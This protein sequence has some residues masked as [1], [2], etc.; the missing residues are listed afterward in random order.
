VR[1]TADEPATDVQMDRAI[2]IIL[3]TG[4][5]IAGIFVAIGGTAYLM[6]HAG[7][8]P[9]FAHF[10]GAPPRL[11]SIS[12]VVRGATLADP[13]IIIQFGLI[14][15]MATPV[16]RV[17][18]CVAGFAVARDWVYVLISLIVLT[19]LLISLVGHSG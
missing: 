12:G 4:V 19:L 9:S 7:T 5:V 16:V 2:G 13:L 3:R 10:Q 18:A 1:K 14:V 8:A 15:L 17:I 11:T 6:A